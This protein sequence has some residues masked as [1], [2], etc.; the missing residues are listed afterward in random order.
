[1]RKALLLA[2]LLGAGPAHAA[3]LPVNG[4]LEFLV[5]FGSV[6]LTGSGI[7]DSGGG[8]GSSASIPAGLFSGA[9]TVTAPITP[10][11]SGLSLITV[12]PPHGNAA[13]TFAPGG[14]MGNSI[15]A[16]L[17]FTNGAPAGVIPLQYVGAG[18]TG[19]VVF[20]G[21]PVTVIGAA[22]TNLGVTAGDATRT[23][24]LMTA[25]TGIPITV[26][27]TAFDKR[28]AGG[29]GTLQLVAPATMKIL[30]GNLGTQFLVGSL[31]L[32]FVP[33]PGTL[34]LFGAGVV[35][36]TAFARTRERS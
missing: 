27:A 32:E 7:G 21:L 11:Q 30:G 4:T 34:L 6:V 25:P 10:P 9:S 18:G 23:T 26:T 31:R 29:V 20:S 19:M 15:V 35:G 17:F 33:E 16:N 36:L 14:A 3:S 5:V 22:W 12:P 2:C 28:T 8:V 1:M 24:M 13:G